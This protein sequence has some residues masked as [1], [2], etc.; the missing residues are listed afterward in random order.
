MGELEDVTMFD[1]V[2]DLCV[3]IAGANASVEASMAAAKT[4]EV[5]RTIFVLD[6]AS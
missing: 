1:V 2:I 5:N 6:Y 3:V 4:Y